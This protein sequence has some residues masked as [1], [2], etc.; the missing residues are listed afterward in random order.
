MMDKTWRIRLA[1]LA[2]ILILFAVDGTSLAVDIWEWLVCPKLLEKANLRAVWETTVPI[3][4]GEKLD[5]LLVIGEHIYGLSNGNYMV[6]LGR[7]TGNL[8]FG[9]S[10]APP[11]FVL[12][13][14]EPYNN[15]LLSIIGGRLVELDARTGDERRSKRL[16]MAMACPPVRNKRYFYLAGTDKRLHVLRA[17]NMVELFQ[18]AA[19]N[20]SRI[21]SV[22]A[23]Q[24]FVVLSTNAGNLVS[25]AADRPTKLWQFDTLEAIIGPVVKD[26][27]SLFFASEDTYVYRVDIV[28]VTRYKLVWKYQ[29]GGLLRTCPRVTERVVYQY[30]WGKGLTAIDRNSGKAIWSLDEGLDLLAESA[31]KA[32]VISNVNTLVVMDNQTAKKLFT[33][34][35]AGVSPYAVNT[36]DSRI[37]IADKAGRI[38]CIEPVG[39]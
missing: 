29:M 36:V 24:R 8:I 17:D 31:G 2:S 22:L 3:R 7:E 10:I 37:Y 27:T 18:V 19:D 32:Y 21:T 5:R 9:R 25:M 30:A 16:K 20:Q 15:E 6:S 23:D 13:G 34:N 26:G 33:V 35:L 14:L 39:Q 4:Q 1:L 12:M 11:G 38:A 28:N